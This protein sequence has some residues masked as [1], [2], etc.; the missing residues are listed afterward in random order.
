LYTTSVAVLCRKGEEGRG[1]GKGRQD[2]GE[3]SCCERK[4]EAERMREKAVRD[5]LQQGSLF[6]HPE[7][8]ASL[9]KSKSP[10]SYLSFYFPPSP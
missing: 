9:R 7:E 1:R 2:E 10:P 5:L 8:A 3:E 4:R 6:G